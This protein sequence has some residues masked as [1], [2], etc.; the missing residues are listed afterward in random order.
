MGDREDFLEWFHTT[1][2]A[3]E[4]ALHQ[5]DSG[6]RF[7]TW[8]E[9]EPVTLFGAFVGAEDPQAARAVFQRIAES[10]GDFASSAIDLIAAD[11]SCDLAY[12]VHR[13]ITSTSV[14]G[15]PGDYVLRVT[16][17]YR[18]EDGEWKVVHRHA[19]RDPSRPD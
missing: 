17:V 6:P 7:S 4:D 9:R 13:E 8:S 3:A 11:V 12:T 18:R 15:V 2:R 1:W 16:Q 10:F 19:D 14:D 5:G